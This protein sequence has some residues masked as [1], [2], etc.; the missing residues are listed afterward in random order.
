MKVHFSKY[1]GTGND[2]IIIDNR[3]LNWHPEEMEIAFLCNRRFG[4]GADGL[5]LLSSVSGYDFAMAYYNSDGKESTMCGN[6][7]RCIT[8]FARSLG[9]IDDMTRFFAVDGPHE[10]KVLSASNR[11]YSVRLKMKDTSIGKIL[12]EGIFIDTGSP[13]FVTMRKNVAEMDVYH[14][15]KV[16]R[17]DSR[18]GSAGSNINFLEFLPDGLYVRTYERGVE[19]E[20]L[21]CGTGV[22]A[23]AL[24]TAFLHQDNPGFYHVSTRGGNLLVTF[25]QDGNSFNNICLEG[26]VGYVFSGEVDLE[27]ETLNKEFRT[28]NLKP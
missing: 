17:H 26:P 2:F 9:L 10:A 22:T 24:V 12:D 15:G 14:E 5:M 8:A 20:T 3:H 16:L 1:Q 11:D 18:F 6:G 4:I 28:L 21:S 13:H 7:G 27:P 25:N 19:D 23:S